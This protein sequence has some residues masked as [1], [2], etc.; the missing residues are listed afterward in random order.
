MGEICRSHGITFVLNCSQAIGSRRLDISN[1][2][3]DAITCVGFKWLCG[4]YGTGFCWM[5]PELR[6]SLEYNQAY[7]LAMQTA[8]DLGREQDEVVLRTDL[9]ARKYDVFGT[10]NFFNFKPWAAAVEYLLE[11]GIEHIEAHDNSLVS[12]LIE[13]LDPEKYNLISPRHGSSTSTLV[14]VS[15]KDPNR[16]PE[17]HRGLLQERIFISLRE[18]NLRISPHLYNTEEDIDALLSILNSEK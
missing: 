13:G 10:A 18:G 14:V 8:D 11:Q 7:W 5:R 3:V 9:G 2:L 6:E 1:T 4:P 15:H 17:I 16:N 12:R